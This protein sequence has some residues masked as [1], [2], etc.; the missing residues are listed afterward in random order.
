[1]KENMFRGAGVPLILVRW[2]FAGATSQQQ[3][4]DAQAKKVCYIGVCSGR[5]AAAC[6]ADTATAIITLSIRIVP[7]CMLQRQSPLH[8]TLAADRLPAAA[9]SCW[10]WLRHRP[11]LQGA[12]RHSSFAARGLCLREAGASMPCMFAGCLNLHDL[13]SLHQP[14]FQWQQIKSCFSFAAAPGLG[15]LRCCGAASALADRRSLVGKGTPVFLPGDLSNTC[16][17]NDT[18]PVTESC[19]CFNTATLA[20][21]HPF[22]NGV[23]GP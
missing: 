3:H 12:C 2:V 15:C 14:F 10:C 21:T 7:V 20:S 13:P 17:C 1:M 18:L 6:E 22:R 9:H 8:L 23:P 11:R 16:R 5:A 4:L 19:S